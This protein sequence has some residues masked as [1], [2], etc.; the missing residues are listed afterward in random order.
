MSPFVNNRRH[1]PVCIVNKENVRILFPSQHTGCD[2]MVDVI[3][4][5]ESFGDSRDVLHMND[6][7]GNWLA[8][9][10]IFHNALDAG[11]NLIQKS[12]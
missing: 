4:S 12:L 10:G 6:G 11:M 3:T 1:V 8:G 9:D 2:V 5:S 7:V